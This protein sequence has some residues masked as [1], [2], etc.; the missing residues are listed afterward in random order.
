MI[1]TNEG[2]L[3]EPGDFDADWIKGRVAMAMGKA[4]CWF[5]PATRLWMAEVEGDL[6][7]H[8]WV[9]VRDKASAL[10]ELEHKVGG[11]FRQELDRLNSLEDEEVGV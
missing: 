9:L 3:A 5:V 2:W 1:L 7:L 8:L 4:R 6:S 10:A 11:H